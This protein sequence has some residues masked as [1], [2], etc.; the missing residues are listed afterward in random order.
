MAVA[1]RDKSAY[2]NLPFFRGEALVV[3]RARNLI[4]SHNTIVRLCCDLRERVSP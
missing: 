1:L 3:A 4:Q 2:G